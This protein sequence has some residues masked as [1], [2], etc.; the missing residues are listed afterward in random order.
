MG[1][2]LQMV[3]PYTIDMI[4]EKA[5]DDTIGRMRVTKGRISTF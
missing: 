2:V 5:N 1:M 4:R 3:T